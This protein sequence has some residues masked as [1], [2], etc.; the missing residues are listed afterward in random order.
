[1]IG[2]GFLIALSMLTIG[3][4]YASK[5][6]DYQAGRWA[7]I[8]LIYI[9]VIGFN[10]TW[11]ICIR[12][13]CVE[14]Q[15]P[16]TRAAVS[17]LGQCA[18]WVRHLFQSVH[19]DAHLP[20]A[21]NWIIAL[22]TPLFLAKSSSGPYFLFGTCS[23]LTAFVCIAYQ[24]ETRG[25]SLEEVD[26]NFSQSPWQSLLPNNVLSRLSSIS[27]T[28]SRATSDALPPPPP[29]DVEEQEEEIEMDVIHL[30]E[31]A[32]GGPW[33]YAHRLTDTRLAGLLQVQMPQEETIEY[34]LY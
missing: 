7:V 9:F 11:A 12:I 33:H 25:S 32:F 8:V 20:Q 22:T 6:T 15:P 4:L 30:P 28:R 19:M 17:S 16:R 34:P 23:L 2:G 13:I 29:E 1:M 3:T 5:A 27:P 21:V 14:I 10:S 24:P 31:V 26:E 18:N